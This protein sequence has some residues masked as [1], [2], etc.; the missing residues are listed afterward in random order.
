MIR[1]YGY[2]PGS[3][4]PLF[5]KQNDTYYWYRTDRL[6]IPHTLAASNGTVVWSGAYDAF[7]NCE[8]GVETIE[9]HLR[10]PGQY[11]D[12]ETGLYYNLNRYYD[13]KTGRYLQPDP[14][15]DGLN[16]YTYV[17]GNPVNA[18]DPQG[19]CALRMIGGG[20][21]MYAGAG[22]ISAGLAVGMGPGGWIVAGLM[23]LNGAD[24]LIAGSRSLDGTYKPAVVESVIN[25]AIPNQ[26]VASLVY[27]GT[28]LGLGYAGLRVERTVQAAI[29]KEYYVYR[30][31]NTKDADRM[32]QSLGLEAK[33]PDGTWSLRRH[34][35]DGSKRPAWQHMIHGYRQ[36]KIS[37]LLLDLMKP[38]NWEL[39]E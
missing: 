2:L 11:Y 14:A 29:E 30:A 10:L 21:E 33:N 1:T 8:V 17:G 13:P 23:I 24:N 39:F 32:K 19:L 20:S 18:I 16:P 28:Q 35:V 27:M 34:I 4:T 7:G 31:L 36:R 9:N 26:T 5:L 38:L 22:L 12:A 6:G 3:S 25:A 37:A 15:G